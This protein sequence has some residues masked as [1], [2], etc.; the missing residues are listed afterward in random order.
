MK[1]FK[2]S[3]LAAA[4]V[5]AA[6]G[7]QAQSYPTKPIVLV[8]PYAAGGPAD[9]VARSLA[10]ELGTE[11][12]QQVVVE[13]K[14]GGGA[15]IGAAYVARAEADGY[16]LLFGTA[17][18]HIVTPL[19]QPTP[20]DGIKDFTFIALAA[21]QPNLLVVNPSVKA[22][23]AKELIELARSNPGKLNY[24][25]SGTGT[26]PHLG[27]ELIKQ[28]ARIEMA[29]IPYGGAAPAITDLVAGRL[30]VG[31][32]NLSGE[33][34]Y[35]KAGKLRALAYA[36]KT[37]S[38]LLPDVPT[39]AEAGLGGAESASWYTVA[40][41][42]GTPAAVVNKLNA[43]LNA[44]TKKAEYRKLMEAQG[45]ELATLTPE[46]TTRFVV[47]DAQRTKDLIKSANLKLE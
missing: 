44:V 32:M 34:P 13:N 22:N 11:L 43:A 36:S 12:G 31:V 20:Y 3:L 39:F 28:Q 33:L 21:N 24:G 19:I 6:S 15:T 42:K 8:N 2:Q 14:A 4:L 10:K 40:A 30:Q 29:H 41:P 46:E 35:V 37:R 25:S 47:D 23:T 26:S 18:A 27:G 45:T 17:A 9:L 7:A 1:Q 38:P 5:L 16:T